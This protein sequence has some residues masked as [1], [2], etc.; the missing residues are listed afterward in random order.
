[1]SGAAIAFMALICTFV[2]GGFILLLTRAIRSEGRKS[3][4]S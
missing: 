4:R 1:M 3:D 2:W